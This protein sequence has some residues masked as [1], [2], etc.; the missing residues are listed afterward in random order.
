LAEDAVLVEDEAQFAAHFL[1]ALD[2]LDRERES[3][4]QFLRL[5]GRNHLEEIKGRDRAPRRP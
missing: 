4:A 5:V 3:L 2:L 1:P